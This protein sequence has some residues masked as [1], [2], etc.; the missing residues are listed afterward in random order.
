[1]YQQLNQYV[2]L[3][4]ILSLASSK[5]DFRDLFLTTAHFVLFGLVSIMQ[6]LKG[7]TQS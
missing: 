7:I 1:M 6:R 4:K 2:H 5:F 3:G